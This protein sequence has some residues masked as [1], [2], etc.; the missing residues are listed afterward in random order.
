MLIWCPL[1]KVGKPVSYSQEICE[2]WVV[3]CHLA[4]SLALSLFSGARLDRKLGHTSGLVFAGRRTEH[5]KETFA[6]FNPLWSVYEKKWSQSSPRYVKGSC[7]RRG[8]R[9]EW[10]KKLRKAV[11]KPALKGS[12][13]GERRAR[14]GASNRKRSFQI[15]STHFTYR[16]CDSQAKTVSPGGAAETQLPT[17]QSTK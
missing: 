1:A 7:R 16:N 11:R 12:R 10:E 6:F 5:M 4:S 17:L 8:Q 9:E 13:N 15:Q 3:V 2:C 14:E